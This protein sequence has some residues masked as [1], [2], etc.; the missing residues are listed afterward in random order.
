MATGVYGTTRPADVSLDDLEVFLHY[1]PSRDSIGDTELTK[2]NP[3]EVLSTIS[4]PNNTTTSEVFGG[5]Y[6]LKLPSSIF[7]QKGI[8]LFQ[9]EAAYTKAC[10]LTLTDLVGPEVAEYLPVVELPKEHIL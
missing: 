3:T 1:T 9:G 10:A 2:L 7:G 6:T 8:L 5:M 4:N